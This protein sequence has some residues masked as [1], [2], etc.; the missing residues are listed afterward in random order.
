M[1][2]CDAFTRMRGKYSVL[3]MSHLWHSFLYII[4]TVFFNFIDDK[5]SRTFRQAYK[6]IISKCKWNI[7]GKSARYLS[8]ATVP[9]LISS[10]GKILKKIPSKIDPVPQ[11]EST[12]QQL[13]QP[14][15]NLLH[16]LSNTHHQKLFN[17]TTLLMIISRRHC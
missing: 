16:Q 14:S 4:C 15:P 13:P 6:R 2:R 7:R 17:P 5:I 1:K 9:S 10:L 8:L 12:P 11:P 3:F